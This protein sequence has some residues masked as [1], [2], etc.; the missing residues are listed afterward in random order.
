MNFSAKEIREAVVFLIAL[1]LSIAVHEFGHAFTADRLGDPTPRSQGRVTLNPIA[2][3]D[4]VGTLLMP[5]LIFFTHAPLI[6]WGKPVQV[7][8]V[9]YTRKL[10][11]RTS[12]ILVTAAGPLMNVLLALIVTVIYTVLLATKVLDPASEL[13]RGVAYAILLNWSLAFF[14]LIPVPPL[15]GG[16]ILGNL[17]PRRYSNVMDMLRQYGFIILMGLMITGVVQYFLIPA[18]WVTQFFLGIAH[19]IA[20]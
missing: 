11:M 5:L 7:S 10:S 14:N 13:T 6:G 3:I 19:A 12:D 9:A 17:L 1:V 4:P 15:D 16:W 2:H 20:F 18:V 8:P